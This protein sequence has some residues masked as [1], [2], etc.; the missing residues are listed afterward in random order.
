MLHFIRLSFQSLKGFTDA[1][2]S[3]CA[4]AIGAKNNHLAGQY[5]QL[6]VI[7][8]LL[9]GILLAFFVDTFTYDILIW[10]DMNADIANIGQQWASVAAW[11]GVI[12]GV[13]EAFFQFMNVMDTD[14]WS[15][16]I[17]MLMS[18]VNTFA[19]AVTLL[20]ENTNLAHIGVIKLG[21]AV[22]FIVVN[23]TFM[24]SKGWLDKCWSGLVESFALKV[25]GLLLHEM[26]SRR[27]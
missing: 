11:A 10:L 16:V 19:I 15:N 14:I 26:I 12:N 3:L 9:C 20:S 25:R 21:T 17:M 2:A 1:Q 8:F 23:I 22:L 6:S 4:H 7:A 27:D 13:N 18:A 5:V 24:A